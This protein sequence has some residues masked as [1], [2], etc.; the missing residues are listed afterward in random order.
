VILQPTLVRLL[1]A[2]VLEEDYPAAGHLLRRSPELLE[3]DARSLLA[4]YAAC[5]E[6][7]AALCRQQERFLSRCA[8]TGIERLFPVGSPYVDPTAFAGVRAQLE[9]AE[10]ADVRFQQNGDLDD[11]SRSVEVRHALLAAPALASAHPSLLSALANDAG[12]TALEAHLCGVATTDLSAA[13]QDL[14]QAVALSPFTS[15]R[16]AT[17]QSNLGAVLLEHAKRTGASVDL[18]D[19]VRTLRSAARHARG[20]RAR[21]TASRNLALGLLASYDSYRLED[22]LDEAVARLET[23]MDDSGS[24]PAVAGELGNALRRRFEAR[25]LSGDL[26]RSISLLETAFEAM[27]EVPRQLSFL[28]NNLAVALLARHARDGK[29][30]D[31]RAALDHLEANLEILDPRTPSYGGMISQVAAG[32]Y[33]SFVTLGV[34]SDLEGA[35]SLFRQAMQVA[36][37]Q[38]ADV[39]D[40]SIGYA[41]AVELHAWYS[42]PESARHDRDQA[43]STLESLRSTVPPRASAYPVV[44]A[45]LGNALRARQANPQDTEDAVDVLRQALAASSATGTDTTIFRIN[46]GLALLQAAADSDDGTALTE[47]V[48]LLEHLQPA[49]ESSDVLRARAAL[50][51]ALAFRYNATTEPADAARAHS[52]FAAVCATAVDLDPDTAIAAA[53]R[54]AEWS[55]QHLWWQQ[56]HQAGS[57]ALAA[58]D[59]LVTLQLG[60]GARL[61]WL[62]QGPG[63]AAETAYASHRC[64]PPDDRGAAVNL[65]TGRGVSSSRAFD[66]QA[67]AVR[68]LAVVEPEL[69]ERFRTAAARVRALS[70]PALSGV[71]PSLDG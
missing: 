33:R 13:Q 58:V 14:R 31:L 12:A 45:N 10:A 15:P 18:V 46:L 1:R 22:A 59:Q 57:A 4:S 26:D 52:L 27:R 69:A 11:L 44:L 61:G 51:T 42:D 60:L 20:P 53:R 7:G 47:V 29:E 3:E 17:R 56:A 16:W 9:Q 48:N 65:E 54:W 35:A 55:A 6:A 41:A 38:A 24:D 40:A 25:G 28:H 43:I 36:N 50:A 49:P 63:L 39:I 64:E 2:Y 30:S 32:R 71:P 68:R 19:A 67:S 62:R 37:P 5:H 34:L 8:T 21:T 70:A 66:R 23:A